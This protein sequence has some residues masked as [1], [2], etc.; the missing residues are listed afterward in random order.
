MKRLKS[1]TDLGRITGSYSIPTGGGV[2][3]KVFVNSIYVPSDV[4]DTDA[5]HY[6]QLVG[7]IQLNGKSG[8]SGYNM[9]LGEA[10]GKGVDS[11]GRPY[12]VLRDGL[13]L[14]DVT[15][16]WEALETSDQGTTFIYDNDDSV[17]LEVKI[18]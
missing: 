6:M 5:G 12:V 14:S 8:T 18:N 16:T 17:T 9:V 2:T 13:G 3:P 4:A 11:T 7:F 15:T 10:I 1:N